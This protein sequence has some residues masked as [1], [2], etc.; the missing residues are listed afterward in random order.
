MLGKIFLNAVSRAGLVL[1]FV[2]LFFGGAEIFAMVFGSATE[3]KVISTV[4]RCSVTDQTS[5][6][7]EMLF[8]GGCEDVAKLQASHPGR[9]LTVARYPL[10]TL[11]FKDRDGR[12]VEASADAGAVKNFQ[13]ATGDI[14]PIVFYAGSPNPT[15]RGPVD[16][17]EALRCLAAMAAGALL[18]STRRALRAINGG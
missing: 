2:G 1:F 11:A 10:A 14:I 6:R 13:M 5:S 7:P 8:N 3:A 16:R 15:V 17:M 4:T 12:D 9:I 18:L